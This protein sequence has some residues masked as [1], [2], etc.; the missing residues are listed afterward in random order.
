MDSIPSGICDYCSK[1]FFENDIRLKQVSN[2]CHE[3]FKL[4][5]CNH[6]CLKS[7]EKNYPFVKHFQYKSLKITTTDDDEDN[8]K[9]DIVNTLITSFPSVIFDFSN[10]K[11]T[12]KKAYQIL[13]YYVNLKRKIND[14]KEDKYFLEYADSINLF[15]MSK[16]KLI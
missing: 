11:P 10:E 1:Y 5:F 9:D 3:V 12:I 8:C 6:D 15:D 14:I 13:E 7:V 2:E 16:I 4:E